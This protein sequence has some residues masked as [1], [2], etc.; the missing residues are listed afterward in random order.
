M[1]R[2]LPP[3]VLGCL[4]LLLPIGLIAQQGNAVS[5]SAYAN[6]EEVV[7][8]GYF[9]LTFTLKNG[10]GRNF[11]A[12]DLSSFHVLS[13]PSQ[14]FRTT[15]VNG[16]MSQE[17]SISY[18]LQPKRQGQLTIGPAKI[19]AAGQTFNSNRVKISVLQ[20][21][22]NVSNSDS[23]E[24]FLQAELSNS[25][26]YLGQQLVLDYMLYS[27]V[28]YRG[29]NAV[30]ESEYDGF[31]H[32]DIQQFDTRVK[33]KVVNGLQYDS[34]IVKRVVLYPQQIGT[35]TIAPLSI[36]VG[37]VVK[38]QR[39]R[40]FFSQ[41]PTRRTDVSTEV[42]NINVQALPQPQPSE[43]ANI[44]G[45]YQLRAGV[46]RNTVTTDDALSLM[47]VLEGEG[48]LKRVAAPNLSFPGD[49]EVYDPKLVEEEYYDLNTKIKGR[50]VFEYVMVPRQ[51]GEFRFQ[52]EVTIFNP[53]SSNYVRLQAIPMKVTVSPGTGER[54]SGLVADGQEVQ[55]LYPPRP[56]PAVYQQADSWLSQSWFWLLYLLPFLL[57]GGAYAWHWR[58]A[59]QPEIDP[60]LQ[61]QQQARQV[62]LAQLQQAGAYREAN[63]S[64]AFYD[65]VQGALLG[66]VGDKLQIDRA[67]LTK[68]NV[69]QKLLELHVAETIS[70]Q[71]VQL[72]S[73]CEMALYAG[74][75][76]AGAMQETYEQAMD[77]LVK[78]ENTISAD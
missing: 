73:R 62:A 14:G 29:M 57:G 11:Q 40:G 6:A 42:L 8:D 55:G 44:T 70:E 36:A 48:D 68:N 56:N 61:R 38:G 33:R 16:Q 39:P 43:F 21:Q 27:R 17:T 22:R 45:N 66:Y 50:K 71:F 9:E 65:E 31:Y 19:Q 18:T 60:V 47:L 26:A 75:D 63:D 49:F 12:P 54:N 67:D 3:F 46:T 34:R 72:L 64:R 25:T 59:N 32:R 4:L 76:N 51:T 74:M 2:T 69:K 78:I 10:E 15:I 24:V 13:G 23:P 7:Q 5:F 77:I 1:S 52:P 58:Q 28:D 30:A 41:V 20:P 37:V 35:L 53:D